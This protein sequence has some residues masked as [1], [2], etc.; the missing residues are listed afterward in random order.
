MSQYLGILRRLILALAYFLILRAI[1]QLDYRLVLILLCTNQFRL[2]NMH[3]FL[4]EIS[5]L[6][7]WIY[8]FRWTLLLLI[9]IV[10]IIVR[11]WIYRGSKILYHHLLLLRSFPLILFGNYSQLDIILSCL[12]VCEVYINNIFGVW[13]LKYPFGSSRSLK[14]PLLA[15]YWGAQSPAVFDSHIFGAHSIHGICISARLLVN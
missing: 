4:T 6:K 1:I 7:L 2:R 13:P 8:F 9:Q 12:R 14:V 10:L 5:N 15:L 3:L 11:S